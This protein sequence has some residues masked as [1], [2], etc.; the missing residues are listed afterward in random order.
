ML[1]NFE[2]AARTSPYIGCPKAHETFLSAY[3]KGMAVYGTLERKFSFF[4][5]TH[6]K[7]NYNEKTGKELKQ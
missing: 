5:Y 7:R 2:I 4:I 6:E 1:T 3:K